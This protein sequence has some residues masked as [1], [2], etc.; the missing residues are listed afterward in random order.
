M[1][2]CIN[3]VDICFN[4]SIIFLFIFELNP[5]AI[6]AIQYVTSFEHK[7][8]FMYIYVKGLVYKI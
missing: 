1:F 5:H 4:Y 3:V 8:I 6:P 7:Q 2:W